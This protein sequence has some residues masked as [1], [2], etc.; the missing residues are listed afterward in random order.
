MVHFSLQN[1][2]FQ[3]EAI[4]ETWKSLTLLMKENDDDIIDDDSKEIKR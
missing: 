3:V 4:V 1:V 2:G